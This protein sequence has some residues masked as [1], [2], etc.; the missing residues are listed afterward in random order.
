MGGKV[1]ST[2]WVQS[3]GIHTV[4]NFPVH[5][6]PGRYGTNV[7]ELCSEELT[8]QYTLLFPIAHWARE[9]ILVNYSPFVNGPVVF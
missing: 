3:V 1:Q 7:C 2:W 9:K 4:H 8:S 5:H 6:E